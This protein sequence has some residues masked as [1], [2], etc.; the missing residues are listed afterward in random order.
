MEDE[1]LTGLE[2]LE[3]AT[4]DRLFIPF[5]HCGGAYHTMTAWLAP[6]EW[7]IFDIEDAVR[8]LMPAERCYH[9]YD[10]CGR[11]YGGAGKVAFK[12]YFHH[13]TYGSCH[14]VYVHRTYTQNV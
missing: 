9:S 10:C 3:L 8:E 7:T 4:P 2:H 13:E 12:T 6:Y 5:D 14:L 1:I 11:Y